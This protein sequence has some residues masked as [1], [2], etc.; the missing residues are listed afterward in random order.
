MSSS[1]SLLVIEDE[2]D[3]ALV[4]LKM[5]EMGFDLRQLI[6]LLSDPVFSLLLYLIQDPCDPLNLKPLHDDSPLQLSAHSS[7]EYGSDIHDEICVLAQG[8][9]R[10]LS[11]CKDKIFFN[12]VS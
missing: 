6:L 10:I 8:Q 1:V 4:G 2:S 3:E 9:T 12:V 5:G 11:L 7:Y